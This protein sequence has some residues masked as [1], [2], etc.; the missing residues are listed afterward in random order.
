MLIGVLPTQQ[1][2][3]GIKQSLSVLVTV[4]TDIDVENIDCSDSGSCPALTHHSMWRRTIE[5]WSSG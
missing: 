1:G 4:D 5:E 3:E 2:V